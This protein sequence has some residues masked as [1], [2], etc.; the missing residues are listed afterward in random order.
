MGP[1]L[2]TNLQSVKSTNINV[3][4]YRIKFVGTLH[5]APYRAPGICQIFA[6]LMV[7]KDNGGPTLTKKHQPQTLGNKIIIATDQIVD[8]KLDYPWFSRCFGKNLP[9]CD[10]LN[11]RNDEY[12]FP[13]HM[14][15]TC[16]VAGLVL[17]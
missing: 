4:T 6:I 16:T 12:F 14:Q 7:N 5:C 2:E 11:S 9:S 8:F 15:I 3:K 1:D 10:I 17:R 13:I